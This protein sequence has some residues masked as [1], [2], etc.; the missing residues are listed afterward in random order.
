MRVVR[1]WQ[2]A[3]EVPQRGA[4]GRETGGEPGPEQ[5]GVNPGGACGPG[6]GSAGSRPS[7]L[8]TV[9]ASAGP[10]IVLALVPNAAALRHRLDCDF[11]P[12]SSCPANV[13]QP[14]FATLPLFQCPHVTGGSVL[15]RGAGSCAGGSQLLLACFLLAC[16]PWSDSFLPALAA[17]GWVSP[18]QWAE[19]CRAS[20]TCAG[21]LGVYY[22]GA[23][24]RAAGAGQGVGRAWGAHGAPG[25]ALTLEQ[26][27]VHWCWQSSCGGL[28]WWM[29]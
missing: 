24:S 22:P 6:L 18:P 7:L 20:L 19:L 12:S 1:A 26:T 23:V 5:L 10:S 8:A 29:Y 9:Q 11:P 25:P 28:C 17:S 27:E 15:Q 4:G 3:A 2:G 16:P 14:L 13:P 21:Y